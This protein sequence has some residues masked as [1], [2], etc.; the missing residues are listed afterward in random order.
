MAFPPP[1]VIARVTLSRWSAH[2]FPTRQATGAK[3]GWWGASR[4]SEAYLDQVVTWRELGFNMSARVRNYDQF[5]SLPGWAIV[6]LDRHTRD[7]RSQ[8]YTL[9]ASSTDI[10]SQAPVDIKDGVLQ[11]KLPPLSAALFVVGP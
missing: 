6:T 11:Y 3:D 2:V 7:P 1:A 5:E 10:K 9:D 4:E 8:V